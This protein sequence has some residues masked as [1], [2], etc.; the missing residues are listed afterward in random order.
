MMTWL[1]NFFSS[2]SHLNNDTDLF[3]FSGNNFSSG[4]SPLTE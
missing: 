2:I 3:L 1:K 4:D